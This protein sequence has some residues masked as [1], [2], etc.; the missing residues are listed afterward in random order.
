MAWDLWSS[1][2][3]QVVFDDYHP[4]QPGWQCDFY[5]GYG[6]DV[7]EEDALNKKSCV[8]VLRILIKKGD[9]EIEEL[10]KDLLSLQNELGWAEHDRWPEI[11]W[12]EK[13]DWLD[14]SIKSL[15]TDDDEIQLLLRDKPAETPDEIVKA[16]HGDY[17][18]D[19]HE[20]IANTDVNNLSS[21]STKLAVG[22]HEEDKLLEVYYSDET[23]KEETEELDFTAEHGV[24]TENIAL[25]PVEKGCN[26]KAVKMSNVDIKWPS[27]DDSEDAVNLSTEKKQSSIPSV[28]IMSLE[29]IEDKPMPAADSMMLC[30]VSK[31]KRINPSTRT[32]ELIAETSV[33]CPELGSMRCLPSHS[34]G[35]K[36]LE[37]SDSK[38]TGNYEQIQFITTDTGQILNSFSSKAKGDFPKEVKLE[39]AI[40]KGVRRDA[41]KAAIGIK[42]SEKGLDSKLSA[43]Q[44]AESRNSDL[45][46]RL[47]DFASKTARRVCK[48]EYDVA[49]A[50]EMDS[51]NSPS[52]REC[53]R[54]TLRR[55]NS[56]EM[57]LVRAEISSLKGRNSKSSLE[58]MNIE[59]DSHI[60]IGNSALSSLLEMQTES[61]P[62]T[63]LL[64]TD[65]E[66]QQE[67]SLKSETAYNISQSNTSLS[68]KPKTLGKRKQNL[69]VFWATEPGDNPVENTSTSSSSVTSNRQKKYS[70]RT[71]VQALNRKVT[72]RAAQPS[73]QEAE[74]YAIVP[75]DKNFSELQ[76][77]RKVSPWPITVERDNTTGN[78]V[79]PKSD[80]AAMDNG[81][82]EDPH[83]NGPYSLAAASH[84][85]TSALVPSDLIGLKN[86]KLNDLRAIAKQLK[87]RKYYRLSKSDLVGQLAQRFSSC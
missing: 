55:M 20:Q 85:E 71:N 70:T 34:D 48:K 6:R 16:L 69:G 58:V 10:E 64:L 5:Y 81:E 74:E 18:Q 12:S 63:A 32:K 83:T 61:S 43:S 33:G 50:G 52:N 65:E 82:Q 41:F 30:S 38:V 72:K 77:K 36:I 67:Q 25:D 9:I 7:I 2:Y 60:H 13:L 44:I 80:W 8:Q 42:G 86:M 57:Y 3:D 51:S 79:L 84:D 59:N 27:E 1:S 66:K 35:M 4:E 62:G 17:C 45:Q 19:D 24:L 14:V 40:V 73:P 29:V 37:K 49:P 28:S 11:A 39:N 54:R 46:Q 68:L 31:S 76:K 22:N 75:Y 53:E 47:C 87:V 15:K 26:L 23:Q 21:G 78:M 56:L